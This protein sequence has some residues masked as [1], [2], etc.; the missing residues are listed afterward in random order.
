MRFA[1]IHCLSEMSF[2]IRK[3]LVLR[4]KVYDMF[5][6]LGVYWHH[7]TGDVH[8]TATITVLEMFR[9]QQLPSQHRYSQ[10]QFHHSTGDVH[11]TTAA[12]TAQEMFTQ[13]L[14]SLHRRCS[15]DNSCHHSI[16]DGHTTTAAI[17]AQ[18]MLTLQQ[19][20]SQCRCSHDNSCYHS[21]AY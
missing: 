11:M 19:L 17:T 7:S 3:I 1:Y 12:I 14:P 18:G 4:C 16:G 10:Q 21:T 13:Q 5:N 9:L 8:T 6:M 15:H 20:P 2:G